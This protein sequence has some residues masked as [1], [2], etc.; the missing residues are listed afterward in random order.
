MCVCV[1]V[2][3]CVKLA[4]QS[5]VQMMLQ[6]SATQLEALLTC[7]SRMLIVQPALHKTFKTTQAVMTTP[8]IDQEKGAVSMPSKI[9]P[10]MTCTK[11]H[12]VQNHTVCVC[13]CVCVCSTRKMHTA[14]CMPETLHEQ[15]TKKSGLFLL[16]LCGKWFLLP[17][18]LFLTLFSSCGISKNKQLSRRST[19]KA[20]AVHVGLAK[21]I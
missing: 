14:Y 17:A 3:V 9:A 10:P 13:V 2:C 16:H 20:Y 19:L 15:S 18:E 21:T 6:K 7:A 12:P 5:Q 11:V 8:H 1:C 4:Q